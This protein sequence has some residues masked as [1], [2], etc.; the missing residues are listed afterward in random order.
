M[1]D[2]H[3]RQLQGQGVEFQG[4]PRAT[5]LDQPR[6]RKDGQRETQFMMETKKTQQ[7]MFESCWW[8]SLFCQEDYTHRQIRV[9][10][11]EVAKF[12]VD[13]SS[14]LDNIPHHIRRSKR[15]REAIAFWI[16]V[17]YLLKCFS[18]QPTLS[19]TKKKQREIW[20]RTL[21]VLSRTSL[22]WNSPPRR[23]VRDFT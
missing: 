8:L 21:R 22:V 15:S 19:H 20:S 6:K 18:N 12:K 23:N 14:V 5:T 7:V 13:L 1:K 11:E 3:A 9:L 17:C 16:S 10:A 4:Y 2:R